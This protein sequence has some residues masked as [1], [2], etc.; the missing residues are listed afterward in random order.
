[1]KIWGKTPLKVNSKCSKKQNIIP[2]KRTPRKPGALGFQLD[3]KITEKQRQTIEKQRKHIK[4]TFKSNL[5]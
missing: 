5:K 2:A 4:K 3:R 1:M